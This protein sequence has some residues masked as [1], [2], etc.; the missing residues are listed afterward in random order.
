MMS[1]TCPICQCNTLLIVEK[2]AKDYITQEIFL[3][4]KCSSCQCVMT[5]KSSKSSFENHYGKVYYNSSKGKFS[6]L[7][8]KVFRWNHKRNAKILFERV[9][10][11]RVLEIGCGRAYL[12]KEIKELGAEVF[13]LESDNAAEWILNNKD[14]NI[15]ALS[16]E[17]A[18]S[19]PFRPSSFQLIIYWHV[20]EHLSD[21]IA[22]L[23]QA[24]SAL[25]KGKV[26]CV[27]IPNVSSYQARLH[28]TTWFH[29][30]VPRHLFHFS[31]KGICRLLEDNGFEIC[32]VESGDKIQNLFGWF[33]SL[34][35][36][37]TPN[38]IN[39]LYRL[40]QGGYPLKTASVLSVLVQIITS[41]VWLP[42]SIFGFIAEEIT[43][44]YGNITIYSKRK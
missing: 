34:A 20:L 3:L 26:L 43:G 32:K 37:F 8:E 27:S 22:S 30:D 15:V 28:L 23:K 18:H 9:H 29:L 13:A 5:L 2:K 11:K 39:G 10:P 33:Q 41:V 40:L 16:E 14:I 44:N 1:N 35:N 17:H 38:R 7:A 31:R 6:P 24:A 42:L 25:E 12:L 36:L 21:P 4:G 19:W